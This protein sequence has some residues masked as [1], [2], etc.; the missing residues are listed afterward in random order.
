MYFN[1]HIYEYE[2]LDTIQSTRLARDLLYFE[3]FTPWKSY[4]LAVDF[5][6][7][8]KYSGNLTESANRSGV[9]ACSGPSTVSYAAK[10]GAETIL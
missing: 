2:L 3:Y 4:A 9:P 10:C 6:A 1:P 8:T 7:F 5:I